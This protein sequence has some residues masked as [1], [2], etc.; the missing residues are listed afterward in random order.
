MLVIMLYK[1]VADKI[2]I[3]TNIKQQ[4]KLI[5]FKFL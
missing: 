3:D 4:V 5:S 1:K 2:K